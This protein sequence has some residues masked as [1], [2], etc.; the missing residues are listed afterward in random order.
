MGATAPTVTLH[1]LP[2]RGRRLR[3]LNG[4]LTALAEARRDAV[5]TVEASPEDA[6]AT[7]PTAGHV[8]SGTLEG[9]SLV[10]RLVSPSGDAVEERSLTFRSGTDDELDAVAAALGELIDRAVAEGQAAQEAEA[11]RLAAERA[12]DEAARQRAEEA[13]R[14]AEAEAEAAQRREVQ[15]WLFA[16]LTGSFRNRDTAVTIFGAPTRNFGSGPYAE[17]GLE[18]EAFPLRP[19]DLGSDFLDGIY[20]R[21]TFGHSLGLEAAVRNT[22]QTVAANLVHWGVALGYLHDFDGDF[23]LG[24]DVAFGFEG[25]YL[26]DNPIM[27]TTE[28]AFLAPTARFRLPLLG[29][30]RS[31]V[32]VLDAFAALRIGLGL[33][34]VGS[35]FGASSSAWGGDFGVGVRGD[36]RERGAGFTYF[37]RVRWA[38]DLYRYDGSGTETGAA[39]G[40][41]SSFRAEGGVGWSF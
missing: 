15:G 3:R 31:Q 39:D 22:D 5:V 23:Q 19:S 27:P 8:I 41:S 2:G 18:V 37:A 14:R 24:G 35:S 28:H 16:W 12:E 9:R 13:A 26:G 7:P 21:A 17:L 29:A 25:V 32:L 11:A 30:G 10:F 40:G 1:E 36:L 4:R 33:G 38:G 34:D 20:A 6:G